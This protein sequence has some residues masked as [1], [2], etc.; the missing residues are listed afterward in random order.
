MKPGRE[1]DALV[2]KKVLGCQ[3]AGQGA[4]IFCG[5]P[6]FPHGERSPDG[7]EIKHYSTDISST[8]EVVEALKDQ[9]FKLS[10]FPENK[11][12]WMAQFYDVRNTFFGESAAHAICVSALKSIGLDPLP[13]DGK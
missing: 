9:D 1:L 4:Y 8:W 3:V 2:A 12:L 11:G 7:M 10:Y 6:S 13:G 5:C